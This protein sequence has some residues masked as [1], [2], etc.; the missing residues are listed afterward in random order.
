MTNLLPD[1]LVYKYTI[2]IVKNKSV[3][4]YGDEINV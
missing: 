1:S 3:R 4:K 2:A